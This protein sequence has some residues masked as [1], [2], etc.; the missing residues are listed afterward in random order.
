MSLRLDHELRQV[1]ADVSPSR[2]L[3]RHEPGQLL[4]LQ[5]IQRVAVRPHCGEHRRS[6]SIHM[7][8]QQV[9]N[10]GVHRPLLI[11][12]GVPIPTFE[13]VRDVGDPLVSARAF[14]DA[15][16]PSL[17][18]LA[19]EATLVEL[20]DEVMSTR[21]RHTSRLPFG[22]AANAAKTPASRL[23]ALARDRGLLRE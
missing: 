14:D 5:I 17:A 10:R 23:A 16:L 22:P 18:A 20:S 9:L 8:G 6:R 19:S 21:D 1:L 15:Y 13:C 3:S 2:E 11:K 7:L 4:A 12:D